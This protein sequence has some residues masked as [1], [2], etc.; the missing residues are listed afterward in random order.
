MIYFKRGEEYTPIIF[1]H[2]SLINKKYAV[3][4]ENTSWNR[5]RTPESFQLSLNMDVLEVKHTTVSRCTLSYA[6][7]PGGLCRK[8]SN[9]EI[10]VI[11]VTDKK[12]EKYAIAS[13]HFA[14]QY[15]TYFNRV[16][17]SLNAL[18]I[19]SR[20]KLIIWEQSKI[21]NEFS[22]VLIPTMDDYNPEVQLQ[23]SKEYLQYAQTLSY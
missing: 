1:Q 15:P 19:S 6:T 20:S 18:G 21:D 4:N 17:K 11:V 23:L 12:G 3:L 9:R 5:V 14:T 22:N 10:L 2:S 8:Y 13:K 7:F 16:K